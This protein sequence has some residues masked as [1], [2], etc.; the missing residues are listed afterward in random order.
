MYKPNFYNRDRMT[1]M[2]AISK[3]TTSIGKVAPVLKDEEYKKRFSLEFSLSNTS[4]GMFLIFP[5]VYFILIYLRILVMN[6][7]QMDPWNIN[8]YS[9]LLSFGYFF[10]YL[11]A[12]GAASWWDHAEQHDILPDKRIFRELLFSYTLCFFIL[13]PSTI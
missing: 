3:N 6:L 13:S 12:M 4:L 8:F 2:D 7:L 5:F 11:I 9:G 10:L 1:V